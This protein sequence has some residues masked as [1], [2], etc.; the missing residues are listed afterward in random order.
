MSFKNA[1]KFIKVFKFINRVKQVFSKVSKV[2][3]RTRKVSR[4]Y[5]FGNL[6]PNQG[7]YGKVYEGVQQNSHREVAIKFIPR[8][9]F[10]PLELEVLQKYPHNHLVP[11]VDIFET[12]KGV[13]L[14]TEKCQG[15]L[16]DWI[17]DSGGRISNENEV[18][19]LTRQIL[20]GVHHLHR[21]GFVHC[22]LKLCNILYTLPEPGQPLLKIIDFGT[23]QRV[24]PG[25]M[26][27]RFV[28][29]PNFIAPEII[30]GSYSKPCD[31]WS[32]GC[33]VFSMLFGY[34]PFNPTCTEERDT[35]Y[36][37]ILK[38][39]GYGIGFPP[40]ASRVSSQ[41]RA[42]IRELLVLDARSRMTAEEALE[43]P[44]LKPTN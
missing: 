3:G 35:V 37:N 21:H 16:F 9:D 28:G 38:G 5:R 14:I 1:T 32:V 41:C 44:W 23:C 12:K 40:S 11:F 2:F 39:F 4:E 10:N 33:I 29:S 8:K 15:D 26:L 31:L 19:K 20:N 24:T 36:S 34:N 22:D 6:F 43:H 25:E 17:A 18:R 27:H 13:Y 7:S 42:F 30:N